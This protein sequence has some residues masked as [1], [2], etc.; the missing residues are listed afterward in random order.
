M[1][2]IRDEIRNKIYFSNNRRDRIQRVQTTILLTLKHEVN[3]S[4][5]DT[6]MKAVSE[7]GLYRLGTTPLQ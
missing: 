3:T 2:P 6:R 7:V 1:L 5:S 4:T